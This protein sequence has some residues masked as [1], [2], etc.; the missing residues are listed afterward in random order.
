MAIKITANLNHKLVDHIKPVWP[1]P[2]ALHSVGTVV[3]KT[4]DSAER[5]T[6]LNKC[7]LM[8]NGVM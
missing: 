4:G 2:D 5:C 7:H 8:L 6:N 3:L 1:S